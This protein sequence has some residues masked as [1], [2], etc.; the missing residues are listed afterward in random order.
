MKNTDEIRAVLNKPKREPGSRLQI[1]EKIWGREDW[2]A[3]EPEYCGKI[4]KLNVAHYCS[5]HA[6]PI[7]KETFVVLQGE[8]LVE[9]ADHYMILKQ[10][11]VVTIEP[12][13]WHRFVGINWSEILEIST[14]H[15]DE[16][17]VRYSESGEM[18]V[19]DFEFFLARL[20]GGE[21]C[22]P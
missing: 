15:D 18:S 14:H 16:D 8:V 22:N 13:T 9:F 7:K 17:V 5:K 10:M 20:N 1:V 12:N 2:L 11:D 21:D 3:N 6:H 19:E 4:L